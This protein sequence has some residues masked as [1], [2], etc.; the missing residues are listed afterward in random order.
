MQ[1]LT[2]TKKS[3]P[4]NA[5]NGI[6]FKKWNPPED[7]NTVDGQIPMR[8]YPFPSRKDNKTIGSGL[9]IKE[10]DGR[11]W[12]QKPTNE[13]GGIKYSFPKGQMEEN[14]TFQSNAIKETWEETG[15]KARITGYCGD[16]VGR[17]SFNRFYYAVRETGDPT[18][19]GW[20]TEAVLLVP[21]ND[22]YRYLNLESDRKF[23]YYRLNAYMPEYS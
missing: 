2:F 17:Y 18:D 3:C 10:P 14:L 22:L 5:L 6:P 9:I 16:K 19:F 20:E 7:W 15:I 12:I 23:A 21:R 11:I 4:V 8:V 1:T 13:F